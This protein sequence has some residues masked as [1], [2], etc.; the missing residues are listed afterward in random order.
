[1]SAGKL[2]RIPGLRDRVAVR[3]LSCA[4]IS[5]NPVTPPI[6]ASVRLG[7]ATVVAALVA[8]GVGGRAGAGGGA[9]AA[10]LAPAETCAAT[11]DPAA[12]LAVK[13][14][15]ILCLVNWAR[16]RHGRRALAPSRPLRRAAF[17]KGIKVAS[18]GVLTHA[19]CG[20][21]PLAEVRQ[22]GFR[23][24]LFG[25]NLWGGPWGVCARAVVAGWLASPPHRENLLR[26]AFRLFGSGLVHAPGFLGNADGAVWVTTFGARS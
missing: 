7:L 13:K 21:D 14:R 15:A 4:A 18:C 16:R 26:P 11:E 10:D 24:G 5:R 17:E 2:F 23:F 1:M 8:A 25:E 6:T 12:A 9:W 22:T 20:T 19:P 3:G